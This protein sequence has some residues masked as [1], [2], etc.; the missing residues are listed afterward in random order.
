MSPV[1]GLELR[2]REMELPRR[3]VDMAPQ[4]QAER[5]GRTERRIAAR[6]DAPAATFMR[7]TGHDRATLLSVAR[8]NLAFQLATRPAVAACRRSTTKYLASA[9]T[10]REQCDS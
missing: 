1:L 4:L 3:M 5:V 7:N 10:S 6:P 8:S 2:E 9:A